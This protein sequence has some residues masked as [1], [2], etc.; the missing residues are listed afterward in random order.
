MKQIFVLFLMI[1]TLLGCAKAPIT[2][3][4]AFGNSANELTAK[5]ENVIKEYND[6]A[7][8]REFTNYAAIYNGKYAK[9]LTSQELSKIYKP[10]D[11]KT[12]K[13]LAIYKATQSLG[14]YAKALSA[15]ASADSIIDIDFA[16]ATLYGSMIGLNDQYKIIKN[17]KEDLFDAKTFAL[18]AKAVAAIGNTIV[19]EKKRKA[20]KKIIIAANPKISVICDTIN[21]QLNA[22]GIHDGISASRQYILSEEIREYKT[23]VK[24][25]T[26]LD[27]RR[28]EIQRLYQLNQ[29]ITTSKLLAQQAQKAIMSIKKSHNTLATELKKNKFNSEKIA[30]TIGRLKELNKHYND[31]D[32]LLLECKNIVKDENSVISCGDSAE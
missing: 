3:I 10:I 18:S 5:V 4:A 17:I 29:G 16:A 25:P 12:K 9:L 26:K 31:F 22:S 11:A 30:S 32:T 21:I 24:Q 19:E 23:R 28:G 8:N 20:I 15:L 2:Q 14:S 6:A 7:L 1:I 27:W 13:K